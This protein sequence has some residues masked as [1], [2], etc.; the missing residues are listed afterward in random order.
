MNSLRY[1]KECIY[2]PVQTVVISRFATYK[3]DGAVCGSVFLKKINF[4]ISKYRYFWKKSIIRD[5]SWFLFSVFLIVTLIITR[6][7]NIPYI[8]AF[9]KKYGNDCEDEVLRM[10]KKY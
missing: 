5:F 6:Q 3:G 4:P 1:N 8:G 9:L 2:F 10:R 7:I